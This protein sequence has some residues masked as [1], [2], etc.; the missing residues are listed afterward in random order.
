ML[1][2][3]VVR[4]SADVAATSS[5]RRKVELIATCLSGARPDEVPV[6]V[7]YLSGA[8][9]HDSIGVGWAT[10]RDVPAPSP[11]PETLELSEVDATLRRVGALTGS[12]SQA[13]RR[14]ELGALFARATEP[15]QRFLRGLLMGEIRQGALEGVMIDAVARAAGVPL[16]DVRRAAM[17]AG[18][19]GVVAAAAIASGASALTRFRLVPLTPI[20]PMLAQPA[21]DIA[22]AFAR[23]RPAAVEWKLDG[24]RI[25]VH[26]L[27]DEVGVFTRTLAD[28]TARVPE[29]VESVRRL[30]VRSAVFDAEA[31][32]LRP[33]GRP[34]DYG[35]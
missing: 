24:A 13:A 21:D 7:A 16:A 35:E 10:L 6:A 1:F 9:P 4:A 14:R 15:E 19:L 25:Q 28:V 26:R 27:D 34:H 33:D 30:P 22:A 3:E 17:L 23:I 20:Q 12:G 29:I 18:D 2:A 32:A 11:P 31:I 5:R 8:L